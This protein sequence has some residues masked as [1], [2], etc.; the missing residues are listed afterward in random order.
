M[1][2]NSLVEAVAYY[3][4]SS[5][6]NVG[7][8]K[9]SL[10]RQKTAVTA[11]AKSQ[12]IT[13]V[14]EFYDAAVS[15]TDPIEERPG[16]AEMLAKIESNGARTVL[17]EDASRFARSVLAQEL[18]VLVMVAR[19]VRVITAS[20]ENLTE[21]DDPTRVMIRQ[22]G[23]AFA[24][25]EKTRLVQKLRS[26]R[27]RRRAENGR[28]EGRKPVPAETVAEAK[29]LARR[30]RKTGERPSLRTIAAKLAELGHTARPGKPY[31]PESVKRMLLVPNTLERGGVAG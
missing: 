26:A 18:G 2:R 19:K 30:S 29:R 25:F 14:G 27:E 17:V 3:R 7:G 5:A 15:G 8:D 24:Q 21:T 22:V 6:A 20:G 1:A 10:S 9:D 28:C 16:F 4:T 12:K 13:L 31:G 23:A 11:Y